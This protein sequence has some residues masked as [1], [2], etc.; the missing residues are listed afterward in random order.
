MIP[1]LLL[2]SHAVVF[3]VLIIGLLIY[4]HK[5]IHHLLCNFVTKVQDVNLRH[6]LTFILFRNSQ[7]L[8]AS[9]HSRS[10]S[11]P[12]SVH[13]I[14]TALPS[15]FVLQWTHLQFAAWTVPYLCWHTST[16]VIHIKTRLKTV[17]LEVSTEFYA[18]DISRIVLCF[19]KQTSHSV[20]FVYF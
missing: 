3:T 20:I 7:C 17:S 18:C 11:Q 5:G 1:K 10:W 2:K 14:V 12:V 6:I 8:T 19:H 9:S 16:P 13:C 15:H 4:I